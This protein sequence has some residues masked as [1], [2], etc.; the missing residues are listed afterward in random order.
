MKF[1]RG[2]FEKMDL[3]LFHDRMVKLSKVCM[4]EIESDESSEFLL[5]HAFSHGIYGTDKSY[6]AGRI[7]AMSKG[8]MKAGKLR[9][10]FA[11]IFLPYSRMKAQ[12]PILEKYPFLPICWAKRIIRFLKGNVKQHKKRLEYCNIE[13]SDYLEMPHFWLSI[14]RSQL[15]TLSLKKSSLSITENRLFKTNT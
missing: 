2:E 7:A 5:E 12:F 10:F 4:G 13:E 1:V 3:N 11:A 9:S 15:L 8:S 14:T 6:K